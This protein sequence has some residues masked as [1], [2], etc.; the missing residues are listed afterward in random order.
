MLKLPLTSIL[1]WENEEGLKWVWNGFD[2]RGGWNKRGGW[3]I[4]IESINMEGGFFF[5][6]GG[7]FQN[8]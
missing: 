6:E 5:E 7:I 3:R 1:K 2:K 4:F 8:R